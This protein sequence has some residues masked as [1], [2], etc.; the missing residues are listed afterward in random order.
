MKP[1]FTM[2]ARVGRW[3]HRTNV[4]ITESFIRLLNR[5]HNKMTDQIATLA[6]VKAVG[7][8]ARLSFDYGALLV[9]ASV[10]AGVGLAT[11]NTVV[12]S[13]FL[14]VKICSSYPPTIGAPIIENITNRTH[15]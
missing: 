9:V 12:V 2:T 7:E 6:F 4:I 14:R 8:G 11:D 15:E 3:L 1:Y 10:I 13:C 5:N